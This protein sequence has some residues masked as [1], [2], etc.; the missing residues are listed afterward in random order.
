ME[1]KFFRAEDGSLH[2][3]LSDGTDCRLVWA[4]GCEGRYYWGSFQRTG[5]KSFETKTAAVDAG[6]KALGIHV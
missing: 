5:R 4:Y 2:K 6:I 3:T 1:T